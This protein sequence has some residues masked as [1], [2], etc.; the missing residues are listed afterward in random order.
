MGWNF[1]RFFWLNLAQQVLWPSL[2]ELERCHGWKTEGVGLFGHWQS[3]GWTPFNHPLGAKHL[4]SQQLL[5][6]AWILPASSWRGGGDH[7]IPQK[8]HKKCGRTEGHWPLWFRTA[9]GSISVAHKTHGQSR[10]RTWLGWSWAE[11]HFGKKEAVRK[12]PQPELFH[13]VWR[14]YLNP[15]QICDIKI[16]QY[17]AARGSLRVRFGFFTKF[18]SN[19]TLFGQLR[20]IWT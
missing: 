15:W 11:P 9:N 12:N 17:F 20:I 14:I 16:I 3:E 5:S 13:F 6:S 2:L 8:L 4:W 1:G 18:N 10:A 7:P 19:L